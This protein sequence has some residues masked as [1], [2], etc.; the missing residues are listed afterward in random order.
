VIN[1]L[2]TGGAE[3][4]LAEML[5]T[6]MKNGIEPVMACS[7]PRQEGVQEQVAALGVEIHF[8][9]SGSL[10]ARTLA[11][12]RLLKRVRPD[13]VHTSVFES[14]V[15]G[16]LAAAGT[17]IPVLTS[18]VNT[19]YD[20]ARLAADPKL[21]ARRLRIVQAIDGFTARTFNTWFHAVGV[22]VR[23]SAVEAL[24][25]EPERVTV[26]ERGRNPAR[27]G[28]GDPQRRARAR[29][30]LG[31]APD[32]EVVLNVGRQEFQKGQKFLLE[33]ADG[34][35]DRNPRAVI[36][37]AG[38][39]GNATAELQALHA[40]LRHRDRVVFLG[41]RDDVPELLSA[42]DV[43]A[44]PS[45]FEGF[46]G[47]LVEAIALGLPVVGWRVPAIGEVVEDG[48]NAVLLD[49][50]RVDQMADAIERLLR[51]PERRRQFGDHGRALFL[52]RYTV[53]AISLRM[54]ELFR[55]VAGMRGKVGAPDRPAASISAKAV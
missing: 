32:A 3:R 39:S 15:M 24:G 18:L 30:A 9:G 1:G 22:A 12:R 14:D 33:M 10:P 36:L 26:I 6:F 40:T 45:L 41:H 49:V 8:L 54:V 31:V 38:R 11:L 34:L 13:L 7:F 47:A 23:D 55:T 25:V 20:G 21:S 37:I 29:Q 28:Q 19:S 2:G 52:E 27:L 43:F 35:L 50:G 5:P 42:A 4:S 17:G 46:S 48:R 16:R 53:E 44:F 51:S